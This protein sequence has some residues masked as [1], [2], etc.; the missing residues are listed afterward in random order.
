MADFTRK[1]R[2]KEF[3]LVA[4]LEYQKYKRELNSLP[5]KE[6][7]VC[8][9]RSTNFF[10]LLETITHVVK[11]GETAHLLANF[12]Y[13]DARLWW[14]IADYNTLIDFNNLKEGD[15]LTIPPNT[16]VFAY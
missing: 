14:F 2:Y 16:E 10:S 11:Q 3:G 1:T 6:V 12:Y 8:S 9:N 7:L 15:E 4:N 5:D 13:G